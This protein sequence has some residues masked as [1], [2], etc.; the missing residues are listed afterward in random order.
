MDSSNCIDSVVNEVTQQA[1]A[2]S[3]ALPEKPIV[4]IQPRRSWEFFNLRELWQYRE[5][6][7]FLA[8]RDVKVRYKQAF[9]GIAW[10]ILQPLFLM[11]I[12]TLFYARFT[13][14]ETGS[15]P[16]PLFA[17]AGL[18]LWTFFSGAVSTSANSVVNNANLITKVYFPRVI[19]PAAS[20]LG[21]LVD[22]VV[23]SVLLIGMMAFYG[24]GLS[25]KIPFVLL[26]IVL[27]TLF[28]FGV[29]TWLSALNVR[30]R[31]IRFA[32]PF[33]MQVWLFV[34]S[35]VVPSSTIGPT[36]RKVLLLNPMSAFVEGWRASLFG[37]PFDIY[38]ISVGAVIT[39]AVLA[40]ALFEFRRTEKSFADVI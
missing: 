2:T 27:T 11:L 21:S 12:F 18:T 16:Y 34:S 28:A 35:I 9:F 17:Y 40:V 7:Y 32:V 3:A 14:I 4:V 5:L 37:E 23:A 8:W 10:A 1:T 30:Y 29:G 36:W 13:K 15:V 33:L 25:W 6:L 19:V 20:V 26:F 39:L 24:V 38:A 22:F 31:D